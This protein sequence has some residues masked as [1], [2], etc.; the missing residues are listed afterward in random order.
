MFDRFPISVSALTP[1]NSLDDSFPC[2]WYR[3]VIRRARATVVR[4][5]R[6]IRAV[7]DQGGRRADAGEAIP[8][9][10]WDLDSNICVWTT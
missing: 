4:V 10:W 6:P 3:R 1:A 9:S 7:R 5:M 8:E 2:V